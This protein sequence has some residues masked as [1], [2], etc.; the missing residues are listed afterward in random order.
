METMVDINNKVNQSHGGG[1]R[2]HRGR[3]DHGSCDK[4]H[5][6]Q[7]SS[8]GSNYYYFGI[9]K[10]MANNYY[11]KEHDMRNNK[12]YQGNYISTNIQSDEQLFVMQYMVNSMMGNVSD[13]S[14]I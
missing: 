11:K 1:Q 12:L 14:N 9:L 4:S 6:G 10:H 7:Q 13:S 3:G 2:N 5:S 8:N